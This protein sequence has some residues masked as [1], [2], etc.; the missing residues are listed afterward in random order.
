MNAIRRVLVKWLLCACV[1]FV[2]TVG[3]G[4]FALAQD[5]DSTGPLIVQATE[6][7][8]PPRAAVPDPVQELQARVAATEQRLTGIETMLVAISKKL[9][10][11]GNPSSINQ[12]V[13]VDTSAPHKCPHC[14][15]AGH[16]GGAPCSACNKT[17][18]TVL[19][20]PLPRCVDQICMYPPTPCAIGCRT[21]P[22]CITQNVWLESARLY[23]SNG[24]YYLR[25]EGKYYPGAYV[26]LANAGFDGCDF[27][28]QLLSRPPEFI[29]SCAEKVSF[30]KT[31]TVNV[32]DSCR[33][34]VVL[35]L[36]CEKVVISMQ[37]MWTMAKVRFTY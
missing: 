17:M 14:G 31:W 25:L 6:K 34:Q 5:A 19:Q 27:A 36:R 16:A 28:Y 18:L 2:M 12:Y 4:A 8:G 10:A 13:S 9:E 37:N 1:C 7:T 29:N 21:D 32:S 3:I 11:H 15:G 33:P 26:D 30:C 22:Q 23:C 20:Q 35:K 24:V